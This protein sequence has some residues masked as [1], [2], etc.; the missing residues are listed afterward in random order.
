MMVRLCSAL[1]IILIVG[2]PFTAEA[3]IYKWVDKSGTI[4]VTD[5]LEKVPATYKD[6]CERFSS[7]APVVSSQSPEMVNEYLIPFERTPGG[8]I[9]VDAV[10]NG[11]VRTRMVFDTGA[12]LV[13][14]SE[15]LARR[16]GQSVPAGQKKVR[17]RTAGGDVEG[18]STIIQKIELGD[19]TG[20]NVQAAVNGHS[21]AFDGFDGL[22][23]LSFLEEFKVTI[24][25]RSG[26]II[27]RKP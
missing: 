8:V 18:W 11:N 15:D 26:V 24:D 5:N 2:Q 17:L 3:D 13:V 23:G 10:L 7:P 19:A 6:R 25:H 16:L 21:N 22:L 14:I 4:H 1:F 9:L 27:L 20:E 12:S